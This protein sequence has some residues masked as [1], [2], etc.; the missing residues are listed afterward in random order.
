ME[1]R[2]TWGG[3]RPKFTDE[4]KGWMKF[5]LNEKFIFPFSFSLLA[6]LTFFS[7]NDYLN[8]VLVPSALL[9]IISARELKTF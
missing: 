5:R 9:R 1:M 4:T 3:A 7:F 2:L 6:K 8:S